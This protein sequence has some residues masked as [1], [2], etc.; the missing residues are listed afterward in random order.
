MNAVPVSNVGI[1]RAARESQV[2]EGQQFI[3]AM[4]RAALHRDAGRAGRDQ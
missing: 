4:A 2:E 1:L 3:K